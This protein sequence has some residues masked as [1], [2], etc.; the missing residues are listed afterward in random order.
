MK[1]RALIMTAAIISAAVLTA[2][3]SM[4]VTVESEGA[5]A[6]ATTEAVQETAAETEA[7]SEAETE[8]EAEE[9]TDNNTGEGVW[10]RAE[11]TQA[12]EAETEEE[13]PAAEE[14]LIAEEEP[15][16]GTESPAEETEVAEEETAAEEETE[17]EA[18]PEEAEA[19]E[20]EAETAETE[21]ETAETEAEAEAIEEPE[22][23]AEAIEEETAAETEAEALVPAE[24]AETE[25]AAE[26]EVHELTARLEGC[27]TLSDVADLLK[28]GRGYAFVKLNGTQVLLASS[29]TF[30][31]DGTQAAIDAEVFALDENGMPAY[32]GYICSG[33]TAN[34]LSIKDGYL[35][36]GGHHYVRKTTLKDGALVTDEAGETFDTAGTP[37]WYYHPAGGEHFV[38]DQ[39]KAESMMDSLFD[40]YFDGEVI[41]FGIAGE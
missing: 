3:C 13:T 11:T 15:E 4:Q 32:L 1:K 33:G 34:P 38:A 5:S 23:E 8:A 12:E 29:G 26:T 16:T 22:T 20:T 17:A 40:E 9:E 2:A 41:N 39:R 14:S 28:H 19:A 31:E 7:A 36:S 10:D 30:N 25:A 35:F 21:A 24:E 6:T 37:S 27:S 18:L